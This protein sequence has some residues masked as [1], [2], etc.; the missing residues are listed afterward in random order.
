MLSRH[1]DPDKKR[2]DLYYADPDIM[3]PLPEWTLVSAD[4]TARALPRFHQEYPAEARALEQLLA[5][6]GLTGDDRLQ[7]TYENYQ[8]RW[9]RTHIPPTASIIY[10]NPHGVFLIPDREGKAS[11]FNR[12]R[13]IATLAEHDYLFMHSLRRL[14]IE[15]T[16][17][18]TELQ[19]LVPMRVFSRFPSFDFGEGWEIY[20]LAAF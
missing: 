9:V 11:G 13:R 7:D 5:R 3:A 12:D 19:T 17:L 16:E 20:Q 18:F 15:Y 8:R 2:S 6:F 10:S 14:N 4:E 1:A